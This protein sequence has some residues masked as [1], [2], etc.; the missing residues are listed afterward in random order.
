MALLLSK[1]ISHDREID[2]SRIR[3]GELFEAV[4]EANAGLEEQ[5]KRSKVARNC[6]TKTTLIEKRVK[7]LEGSRLH[8]DTTRSP[9]A[10]DGSNEPSSGDMMEAILSGHD[11]IRLQPS[12]GHVTS[13]SPE[14]GVINGDTIFGQAQMGGTPVDLTMNSMHA[15]VQKLEAQQSVLLDGSK[16][17]GGIFKDLAFTSETKF[18]GYFSRENVI[19]KGM[20]AFVDLISIWV[21]KCPRR[22]GFRRSIGLWPLGFP[23]A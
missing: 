15:M 9:R 18:V 3:I 22:T 8:I 23:L 4:Y 10:A 7:A 16:S 6:S 21:Y 5:T 19:G 2:Q 17:K 14:A 20:A 13:S 12:L 1:S 11:P